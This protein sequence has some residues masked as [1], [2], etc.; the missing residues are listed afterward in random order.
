MNRNIMMKDL[1]KKILAYKKDEVIFVAVDGVDTSGKTYF[2]DQLGKILLDRPVIRL[3]I[4][5]FHNPKEIRIRKGDFNPLGYY[6]DSFN[7]DFLKNQIFEKI[8]SGCLDIYSQSFDYKNNINKDLET[9]KIKIPSN[10]IV[11]FDG[12]FLLRDA[13][14]SYWD[15]R[16]FLDVS[17]NTVIKRALERDLTYFKDQSLLLEKYNK[18]YIPGQQIYLEKDDPLK[19]ADI[20]IDNND[21]DH[22]IIIK[23]ELVINK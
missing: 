19:K 8:K 21:Y 12:V 9:H 4:D 7:Y 2:A 17:F 6:E 3:S 1:A 20:I 10:A 5:N 16:I 13:I 11:I 15:I 22:P 18:R 23:N 14:N